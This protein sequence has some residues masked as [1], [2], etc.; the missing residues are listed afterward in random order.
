MD[1]IE[2]NELLLKNDK[3]THAGNHYFKFDDVKKELANT[4]KSV[5]EIKKLYF[6]YMN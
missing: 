3:I 2:N 1:F 5:S 6:F 4:F